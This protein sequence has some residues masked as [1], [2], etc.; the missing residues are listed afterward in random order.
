MKYKSAGRLLAAAVCACFVLGL[1]RGEGRAVEMEQAFRPPA[2]PLVTSDPYLSIW[3][4]ADHLTDRAT[5]HWTHRE[6]PLVSLI[7]IDGQTFRL[8]GNE[9]AEIPALPQTGLEV[10]PTRSIFEFE[11]AHVH[12]T[13]TFM[14]AALPNDLD[15]LSLPLSFINWQA[16]SV[17]GKTHAISIYDSASGQ[18][19]VNKPDEKV[20]WAREKAGGL[21]TLRVGTE[22]QPILGS[23]GDDHRINW[24]Y[25]YVAATAKQAKSAIGASHA[26]ISKFISDGGLP[27]EDDIRMPRPANDEQPAMAFAFDLG[28][29][30]AKAASRQVMVA[31]D[32]IYAIKYFGKRLRP[33]WRRNGATRRANAGEGGEG[34][35]GAAEAVH[36]I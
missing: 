19:A 30:G 17:D 22:E 35:S 7:R 32:E 6:H 33:Y 11:D 18:L 31:Y 26:L 28:D 25:A 3:C 21:T 29:V 36:C 15:A 13:M 4:E 5:R 10:T 14:T 27:A 8:M 34:L 24:G 2:V 9:P 20:T 23:S 16:R 12:V 1:G